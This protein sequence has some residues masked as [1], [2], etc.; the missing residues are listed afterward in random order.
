M[1][2]ALIRGAAMRFSSVS[3]MPHTLRLPHFERGS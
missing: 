2:L 1:K 3:V